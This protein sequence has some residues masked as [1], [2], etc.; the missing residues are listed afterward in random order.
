MEKMLLEMENISKRFPGVL[1]LAEVSI[2]LREGEVLG[3][4]G[5][6]GAGKSTLIK[7]LAGDY[8]LDSGRIL[9]QGDAGLE[10]AFDGKLEQMALRRKDRMPDGGGAGGDHP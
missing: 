3:L 9:V 6:N 2:D 4:L 1:A 8:S 7:I 5:E 10:K